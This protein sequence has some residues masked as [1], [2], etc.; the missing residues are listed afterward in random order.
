MP[1]VNTA[2]G[3]RPLHEPNPG[4]LIECVALASYATALF[5]GDV[6]ILGGSGDLSGRPSVQ[7]ATAGSLNNL[8][9]I[10]GIQPTS[11]DSLGT[12]RGTASTLRIVQVAPGYPQTRFLVNCN[13][14]IAVTDIGAGYDLVVAAG[15]TTTGRSAMQLDISTL[16]TAADRTFRM[17]G[18]QNR[19]DN[20]IGTGADAIVV[21]AE[22][23]FINGPG[24]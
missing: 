1:N 3:F 24:A 4:E 14:S 17:L 18:F 15:S 2:F 9:V 6:V 16:S 5:V 20:T 12:H 23:V 19:P 7:Q 13:A 10:V 8:G 21:F 11:P 22:S